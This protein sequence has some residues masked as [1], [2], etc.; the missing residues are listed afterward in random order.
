[1]NLFM[2]TFGQIV[3]ASVTTLAVLLCC[4]HLFRLHW[5]TTYSICATYATGMDKAV[6]KVF[7]VR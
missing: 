2:V 6:Q 5:A 4:H 3:F 7:G 1:M